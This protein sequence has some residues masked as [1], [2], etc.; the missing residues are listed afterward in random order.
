MPKLTPN[1][2]IIAKAINGPKSVYGIDRHHGLFLAVLGDGRA[3]W[4]IRYVPT[5]GAQQRW[6][7]IATDARNTDFNAVSLK[8][9]E[10]LQQL[11]LHGIDPHDAKERE[12]R[13]GKIYNECFAEWLANPRRKKEM[14]RRTKEEYERIHRLHVDPYIGAMPLK[15]IDKETITE[16]IERARQASTNARLGFRGLQASKALKLVRSVLEFAIDH[17][18][19]ATNATRGIPDPVPV[20]HPKGKQ[21]RPLNDAELRLIWTEAPNHLSRQNARML[22]LILL[23]G[24]RVSEIAGIRK[25]EVQLNGDAHLLIPGDRE[26]NKSREDQRVPLPP[27]A[28]SILS[29]AIAE[30]GISPFVFPQRGAPSKSA[31]RHSPSWAFIKFRGA[32]GIS[33]RIRLHDARGLIVDQLAAMGVPSEYRSHVLHHTSDMRATLAAKSYSTYDHMVEKRRALELWQARLIEII[34]G[35]E[36]S[37]LRW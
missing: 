13:E 28:A 20:K 8:A 19:V 23:L 16:G 32:L 1:A 15:A 11:R 29:E 3:S 5:P 21:H 37:G 30:A 4:R 34:E 18:Y 31:T 10:L 33:Q 7:T 2:R 12:A 6:F 17:Q 22:K 36:P 14:R 9:S 24:K 35:R 26:G 25:E 27:L